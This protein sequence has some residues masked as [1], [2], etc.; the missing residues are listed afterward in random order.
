M[1]WEMIKAW[2]PG[3]LDDLMDN[4]EWWAEDRLKPTAPS[5]IEPFYQ[6]RKASE[7]AQH[8]FVALLFLALGRP[9]P[10]KSRTVI[11][12]LTGAMLT[13][14]AKLLLFLAAFPV[15]VLVVG[16]V[17]APSQRRRAVKEA[18]SAVTRFIWV[19]GLLLS[20]WIVLFSRNALQ[21]VVEIPAPILVGGGIIVILGCIA[22]IQAIP[23]AIYWSA[24]YSFRA[25]D[26][27]PVLLP[28]VAIT[29]SGYGISI[30]L[31]S[32][33]SGAAV[34]SWSIGSFLI[35][36]VCA[37]AIVIISLR[38]LA[39]LENTRG[40]SPRRPYRDIGAA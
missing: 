9:F 5:D 27:S 15:A 3:W 37:V 38:E 33:I 11:G 7:I 1:L 36:L 35:K 29:V 28:I 40:V 18:T 31:Y 22:T 12:I 25:A 14:I 23:K 21:E 34:D 24:R 8:V 17:A 20:P 2:I 10:G 30:E 16:M 39:W 32:L 4:I 6:L 13:P 19:R 26:Y